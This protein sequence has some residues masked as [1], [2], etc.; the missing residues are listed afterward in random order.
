MKYKCPQCES[1]DLEI[2]QAGIST[3]N[4]SANIHYA[5]CN[6]LIDDDPNWGGGY[7]CEFFIVREDEKELEK[8]L[9]IL[10]EL[11]KELRNITPHPDCGD[12]GCCASN[13]E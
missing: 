10:L 12:P 7:Y 3:R 13:P 4:W 6:A 11:E 9:E 5:A 2:G 8:E 1:E